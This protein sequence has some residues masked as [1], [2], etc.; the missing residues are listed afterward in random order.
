MKKILLFI[1]I[2]IASLALAAQDGIT[3][4][5]MRQNPY[6]QY[7]SPSAFLP[8]NGHV[9]VTGISNV[10]IS[11]QNSDLFYKRLFGCNNEGTVTTLRLN[12]FAD[13]L[14]PKCNFLNSNIGVN[15][16]DFGFRV[17]QMYFSFSYRIRSDE[18][19][20]YNQDV[21]ALPVHGN[22]YYAD[23]NKTATPTLS[24]SLNAYQEISL[25][26]QAEI[27]PQIYIGVRPKLLF[28]L[29]HAKTRSADA[30]IY[31]NPEDYSISISHHFDTELSCFIPYEINTD[32]SGQAGIQFHPEK[33]RSDW[34]N[35]FKNVGASIDLGFTYRINN[36]FGVSASV[37]DL[38]FIC[39]KTNNYQL[40]SSTTD[41][42]HYYNDG[43][44]I[45]SGLTYDDIERIK[46]NPEAI[47]KE[48]LGYFPLE[49]SSVKTFTSMLAGRF[50]VEGYCN[51]GKHHRFT[52][53]FQGRIVN[54]YFMPSFT[55]A[56]N[57]TFLNI[58]DLCV[59]YTIA[60]KSYGNLGLGVGFNLGVFHIYA[61][62]DNF[63]GFFNSKSPLRSLLN[64]PSANLQA[65]IV[66]DWGKLQETKLGV[67]K[68][69]KKN[70]PGD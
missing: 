17:K 40:L 64:T 56:W 49:T 43:S 33:L 15:L 68:Y 54:K 26:I 51:V 4:H 58:F 57:G 13:Q 67:I 21:V 19:F 25:G 1:S 8:Y 48:L 2:F 61:S 34:P 3:V 42:G 69:Q 65:G 27:T 28:G 30:S 52:A 45:F 66:F 62:T 12:N 9:G 60:R 23:Q 16:I 5:F 29:A 53:L 39:W 6:S 36:M 7:S 55:I 20:F 11:V 10:N 46:E 59:N 32:T 24:L 38:G 14:S 44:F 37:L 70:N 47:K 35:M 31:T 50:I 41:A 63:F 18:Y 22:M